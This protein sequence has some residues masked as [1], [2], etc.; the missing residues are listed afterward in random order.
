[1]VSLPA[2]TVPQLLACVSGTAAG[3]VLLV[4]GVT[5]LPAAAAAQGLEA[6]T[7]E[8]ALKLLPQRPTVPVRFVDPEL[9]GDPDAIRRLDAFLV[10][11]LDGRLRQVIYLNRRSLMVERALSGSA[12]DLAILAAV[13][14]HEVEHLRGAG[15][16]QARAAERE[17]FQHLM[18]V[19]HVSVE[20]GLA[21]L[22]DVEQ[23]HRLRQTR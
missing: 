14:R 9:A 15:E 2:F 6:R 4:L 23:H 19:G 11:E 13:I 7:L 8:R 5:A 18:F 20:E 12:L 1:M 22:A 17:F 16:G 10:R 21:Y 3:C